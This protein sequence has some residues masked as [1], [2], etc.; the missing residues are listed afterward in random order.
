MKQAKDFLETYPKKDGYQ[1]FFCP[2]RV[3]LIGEHIDYNGGYVLPCA[4]EFGI[5]GV[6]KIIEEDKLILKSR[7]MELEVE[8]AL[9]DLE[10]KDEHG[11]AN[12]PKGIAKEFIN[13]GFKLKGM[14]INYYGNIPEGAGLSSSAAM[15]ILTCMI[16]DNLHNLNV[17]KLEW[18]KLSQKV[19]NEYIGV[20]CGIMDQ[21]AVC[22][23]KKDHVILLDCDTLK[24]KYSKVKM[25]KHSL[26]IINSNKK[27]ELSSSKYNERR[28]ECEEGLRILRK[29]KDIENLCDLT[30]LELKQFID[31]IDKENIRKRVRHVIMENERVINSIKALENE[32][33]HTFGKMMNQSH[34]SLRNDYEVTGYELDVLVDEA[35]KCD[36]VLGSRMTGAGFGGCTITLIENQHI[37]KFEKRIKKVYKEKTGLDADFYYSLIEDGVKKI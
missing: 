36:G 20:N 12:Y 18:I 19:E 7:N 24:Y 21:F 35:R 25:D 3:N 10:Y 37:E 23:G 30:S 2:G 32:D 22:M 5:Y 14:R 9:D 13:R 6:A 26:V 33:L 4:L 31:K 34:D 16:I 15:E 28:D 8:V 11:W 17:N 1:Q 27:R 29:Y